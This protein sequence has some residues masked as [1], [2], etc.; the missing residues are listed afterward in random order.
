[1]EELPIIGPF[2]PEQIAVTWANFCGRKV[3]NAL[4][5]LEH[6]GSLLAHRFKSVSPTVLFGAPEKE[7][8]Q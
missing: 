4:P 3:Y 6:L 7:S 8:G 2:S 1:M 5:F